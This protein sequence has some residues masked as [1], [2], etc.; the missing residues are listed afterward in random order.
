MVAR[1]AQPL[2]TSV[3]HG[4]EQPVHPRY[5]FLLFLL[6]VQCTDSVYLATSVDVEQLF[7]Q[8]RILLS[9]IRNRLSAENTRALICLGAWSR[10]GLGAWSRL[11]LVHDEDFLAVAREPEAEGDDELESDW[12]KRLAATRPS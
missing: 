6:H 4:A 10:L 5:V 9:H 11:G 8:A 12:N 3:L 7:S 2:S 1:L